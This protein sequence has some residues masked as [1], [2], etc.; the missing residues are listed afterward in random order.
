MRQRYKYGYLNL[1]RVR[2]PPLPAFIVMT[3]RDSGTQYLLSHTGAVGSLFLHLS[4][5]IPTTP[6]VHFYGPNDGPYVNNGRVRLF[7][8]GD[9]LQGEL[10]A[11][12]DWPVSNERVLTRSG[13]GRTFLEVYADDSW[14]PGDPLNLVEVT[15]D[16]RDEDTECTTSSLGCMQLPFALG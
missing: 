14:M 9:V 16:D 11:R 2:I 5:T 12:P 13:L 6:D 1:G 8:E 4:T 3:A 7:I 15:G 10:V